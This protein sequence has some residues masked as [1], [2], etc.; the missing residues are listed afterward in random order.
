[1][2][3]GMNLA[4]CLLRGTLPRSPA[5][6]LDTLTLTHDD[7]RWRGHGW[8]ERGMARRTD[9]GRM[10]RNPPESVSLILHLLLLYQISRAGKREGG[11]GREGDKER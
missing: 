10:R 3:E 2:G 6:L 5:A 1:M 9:G 7:S 11:G 4:G 8:A